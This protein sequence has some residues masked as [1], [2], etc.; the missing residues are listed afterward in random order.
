MSTPRVCD[1]GKAEAIRELNRD[2]AD[3]FTVAW[4]NALIHISG[5]HV[6]RKFWMRSGRFSG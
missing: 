3:F 2:R 6:A 4:D 5:M 1:I